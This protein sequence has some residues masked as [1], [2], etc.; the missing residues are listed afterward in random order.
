MKIKFFE[1]F[2]IKK[3]SRIIEL[4][5]QKAI[6]TFFFLFLIGMILGGILFLKYFF[7]VQ[8]AKISIGKEPLRLERKIYNQ[9]LKAWE[10][11]ELKFEKA[12]E[13]IFQD[14]FKED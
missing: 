14:F 3:I 2:D 6:F 5:A 10:E 4:C 13:E 8:R 1:K 9:V 12:H 11:R 7:F